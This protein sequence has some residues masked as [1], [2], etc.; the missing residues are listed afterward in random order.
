[1]NCSYPFGGDNCSQ[2]ISQAF[3]EDTEAIFAGAMA[4]MGS[5]WGKGM[6][7]LEEVLAELQ[8]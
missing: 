5:G 6:D 4:N 7:M 3:P 8:A 1:M 2:T